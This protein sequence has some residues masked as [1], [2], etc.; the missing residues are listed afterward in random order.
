MNDYNTRMEN[1][2]NRNQG[3]A[4]RVL[5]LCS[6]GLLR[7]PTAANVIH[8]EWGHNTRSAGVNGNYALILLDK[9]LMAWAE[10]V[11]CVDV[12]S[13]CGAKAVMRSMGVEKPLRN[14]HI[15]DCHG[16]GTEALQGAI[17]DAY[18]EFENGE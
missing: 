3:P 13:E 10:E 4:K 9:V 6:A 2:R 14:L 7:S 18:A 16:W 1:T 8:R 17:K 12:E 11:V 15:P 5:C